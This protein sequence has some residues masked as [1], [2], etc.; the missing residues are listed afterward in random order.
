MKLP[1]NAVLIDSEF[2]LSAGTGENSADFHSGR[3]TQSERGGRHAV[4]GDVRLRRPISSLSAVL[5]MEKQGVALSVN[6]R[7]E[8]YANLENCVAV[9]RGHPRFAGRIWYDTFHQ[10]ILTTWDCETPRRWVDADRLRVAEVFQRDFGLVKFGDDLVEK[11]AITVA[12]ED[13]RDE[14]CDWLTSLSWDGASRLGT[15]LQHVV[16][17]PDD[18]Y[19]AAVGRNFILSMVVRGMRPGCKV[20]TMPVFEGAQGAGKSSLLSILGGGFYAELTESMD[21]KDF[22]VVIQGKWLVEIA[23]LDAFRRSDIRRI[24]QTLSSCQDR[25][26]LPYGKHAVDLPRRVVFAGSTNEHEY[27]RDHT[28]ARRFWPVTVEGINHGW[29]IENR[30]QLFAEAVDALRSGASWWEMPV[31][32]AHT[33]AE[34]RREIDP[35]ED[36]VAAFCIGRRETTVMEVL[37][38]IGVE[39]AKQGKAEQMRVS[40]IL[41]VLGYRRHLRRRAGKPMRVWVDGAV[42]DQ[43]F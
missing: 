17:A 20:D 38:D 7:K 29:L 37:S 43:D 33:Q 25:C 14:L 9:L 41:S 34:A 30:E 21:N 36:A 15:W 27:L 8:P 42:D 11:A 18:A 28:G 35:W 2:E 4:G 39:L 1:D 23:E 19:H 12:H 32:E 24:K 31:A 6:A 5:L 40:Q 16:G 3:S 13:Q 10:D 22:F 26:R